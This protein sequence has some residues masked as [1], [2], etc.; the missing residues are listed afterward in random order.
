MKK[1]CFIWASSLLTLLLGLSACSSEG[2][3]LSGTPETPVPDDSNGIRIVVHT[4]APDDI[5]MSRATHEAEEYKVNKLGVY[6]FLADAEGTDDTYKLAA[7]KP[8]LTTA[9]SDEGKFTDNGDGTLSYTLPIDASWLGKSAKIA[10]IANDEV[11]ATAGGDSP[12]TLADFKKSIATNKLTEDDQSADI[13]SGYIYPDADSTPPT[14]TGLPMS[15]MASYSQKE[16]FTISPLGAE[17]SAS[18]QRIMARVD[19]CNYTP[20]LTI[21]GIKVTH[22]AAQGYLFPQTTTAAPKESYFTMT[23]TGAYTDDLAAD[24]IGYTDP[25]DDGDAK[26]TNTHKH[27]FY[28]YE[29]VNAEHTSVE[30]V[31]DYKLEIGQT[32]K[33]GSVSVPLKTNDGYIPTT[34]N[35]LYTIVVG[36]GKAIKDGIAV[37][38]LIVKDWESTTD[39]EGELKP[40]EDNKDDGVKVA[41]GDFYLNDGTVLPK[42]TELTDEQKQK[43]IGIVFQTFKDAPGRFGSAE[44]E[45]LKA[46]GINFPHGLVMAVKIANNGKTCKWKTIVD[47]EPN[48]NYIESLAATYSDINGLSNYN[49]VN[50][51]D[52]DFSTHP[53]FKAVADFAT[54]VQAPNKSTGWFLPSSG[55]WWDIIENLCNN[56][57]NIFN[58]G[59]KKNDTNNEFW[60][61]R[62]EANG[63]S[64]NSTYIGN[65]GEYF[66]QKN[67]NIHLEK[68][69]SYADLFSTSVN[70]WYWTSSESSITEARYVAFSNEVILVDRPN[71]T[72]PYYVRAVLA[73]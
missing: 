20:N 12:T 30:V 47:D 59:D 24:G 43:V 39:I 6:L 44:R 34:R 48:L 17:L 7:Q 27:M 40:G 68:L 73:F 14:A 53:A 23:P 10:L 41:I 1:K 4:P 22:A 57:E 18:L 26:A 15:A 36:N 62:Y 45:A 67:I 64:P 8:A 37:T 35:N 70:S 3:L 56:E 61:W 60:Y 55:Q 19:V 38:T 69:S 58:L 2:E 72:N 21:T 9:D 42:S 31:I 11:T 50:T 54:E 66:A 32:K 25:Q 63:S 65:V 46:K 52:P 71:K 49:Q 13:I 29:Q 33:E 5:I 28:L 16:A 51:N